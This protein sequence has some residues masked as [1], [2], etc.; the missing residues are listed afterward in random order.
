MKRAIE[1]I[2][3]VNLTKRAEFVAITVVLTVGF[4]ITQLMPTG[5]HFWALV[6]LTISAYALSVIGLR[7]NLRGVLWFTLLVLPTMYTAGLGL[8][9]FLLPVRWLTRVPVALLY[10]FGMYFILLAQNI[11]GVAMTRLIQLLR[12]AQAVSFA[13]TLVTLY[14]FLNTIF[15]FHFHAYYNALFTWI[16][17]SLLM[18]QMF[19]AITLK[20]IVEREVLVY[21]LVLGLV[22]GE[23][24]YIISFWAL[25]PTLS[26]LFITTL[27]YTLIG[28]GQ[29][30]FAKRLFRKNITE[31]V[32][33]FIIVLLFITYTTTYR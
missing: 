10:A 14:L 29:H 18:V 2:S 19:W 6:V 1:S 9:Y 8:F 25:K 26:S 31:Y 28:I 12:V 27:A 32:W 20:P 13:A 33:V 24:A 21:S 16:L 30:Y 23:M 4:V 22:A 11:Y 17:V 7:E 5:L 15:T 3:S